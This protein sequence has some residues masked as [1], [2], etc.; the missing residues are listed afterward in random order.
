MSTTSIFVKQVL[1]QKGGTTFSV[2]TE[3]SVFD[4]L[5][6]MAEHDIG[7]VLVMTGDSLKGI[8]TER[9]YARKVVLKGL[10]S[11]TATVGEMMTGN[12]F[13]V[14]PDDD[15][16]SVMSTMTR[17]RFRHLPVLDG[18]K[19]VGI[20][21]IGDVVKAVMEEQEATIQQLSSYIAGDL[22]T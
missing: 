22:A 8:F 6:L 16:A 13:T 20:I 12:V 11:R 10:T 19:V 9:D 14:S 1:A 4:A 17:K 7:A 15:L 3:T 2:G 21:T 18:G 5:A